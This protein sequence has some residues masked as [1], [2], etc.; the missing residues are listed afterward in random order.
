MQTTITAR[1]RVIALTLTL[2]ATAPAYTATM[3]LQIEGLP[4]ASEVVPGAHEVIA[5]SHD[6]MQSA[7][8]GGAGSGKVTLSDI[9]IV[10]EIDKSSPKLLQACATGKHFPQATLTVAK[11]TGKG[12]KPAQETYLT[13]KLENVLV[14]SYNASGSGDNR[15]PT[16]EF[17]LNFAKITFSYNFQGE[18]TEIPIDLRT[19]TTN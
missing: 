11:T 10:K 19:Q 1:L 15:E 14:S 3:Y 5:Y 9:V 13:I 6:L 4:G 7:T 16:D 12:K 8:V 17:S 18:T 2:M